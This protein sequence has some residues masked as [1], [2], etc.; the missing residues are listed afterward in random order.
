ML[1]KSA[2]VSDAESRVFILSERLTHHH[3]SACALYEFED[4]I[5]EWNSAE[6]YAPT[7]S[8]AFSRKIYTLANFVTKSPQLSRLVTPDPNPYRL[9]REYDLFFYI[10]SDIFKLINITSIKNWRQ[11]CRK[12]VCLLDEC[13]TE[14]LDRRHFLLEPLKEF[15]H[16]FVGSH[17]SV[18][19]VARYT[20]RPCSYLPVGVDTLNLS[21]YPAMPPRS[22]D[23]WNMGRRSPVTHQALLKWAKQEHRNYLFDTTLLSNTGNWKEHRWLVSSMLKRCRYFIANHAKA[24]E[25]TTI[26]GTMEIGLRYFEGAAA[27]TVMIGKP[28]SGALFDRYFGWRD[29]VIPAPFDAP[30]I[31]DTI[32]ELEAQPERVA[33][34]R[35]DNVANALLQH[36]WIYRWGHILET[37]GLQP[38]PGMALR[39]A[40]LQALATQV[41]AQQWANERASAANT[42]QA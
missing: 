34:I 41:S 24:D 40:R 23:V 2:R 19:A 1:N 21:P 37:I 31:A 7:N 3:V 18:E 29:A 32:L 15:D 28:P 30:D 9:D 6:V 10:C 13:W 39:G 16:I 17:N 22:I 27:G 33:R 4:L 25:S 36:D 11:N 42:Q 8:S 38:T 14:W 35:R 12:A 20:G 26:Q 5:A